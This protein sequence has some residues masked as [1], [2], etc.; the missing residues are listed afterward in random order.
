MKTQRAS[1]ALNALPAGIHTALDY[2]MHAEARLDPQFW[3]YL[4]AGSGNNLSLA[5]NLQSFAQIR[6][7]P[8]MLADVRGGHTRLELF[9]QQLDQK[10]YSTSRCSRHPKLVRSH[11]RRHRPNR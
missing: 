2:R 5:A 1:K 11:I 9:G 4:D 7:M 8:R 10:I 3:R 6:L